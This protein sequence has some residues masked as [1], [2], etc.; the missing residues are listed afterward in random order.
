MQEIAQDRAFQRGE[1]G[2]ATAART[3]NVD[4]DIVGDAA[5]LD[6]QHAIGQRYGF[7]DI[8]RD[9]DRGKPL[10]VPYPLQ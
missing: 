5:F 7:R 10:I 8:M 1:I 3:W 4:I 2:R 9:E 6:H